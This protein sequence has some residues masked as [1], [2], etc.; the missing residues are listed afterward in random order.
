MTAV[1]DKC[2]DSFLEHSLFVSDDDVGSFQLQHLFKA[3]VTVD[4]TSVKVVQVGG[5][6]SAA[7]QHYHRTKIGRDYGNNVQYHPLGL[8]LGETE[9]LDDVQSLEELYSL[10]TCG[11]ILQLVFQLVG[12]PFK[13]VD[14]LGL[15]SDL[16]IL[17]VLVSLSDLFIKQL[18]DV[19]G[20]VD[21]L[22]A[23][24]ASLFLFHPVVSG[25]G[26]VI[27]ISGNELTNF[28]FLIVDVVSDNEKSLCKSVSDLLL[29]KTCY[30]S[31]LVNVLD[32]VLIVSLR[33]IVLKEILNSLCT[34]CSIEIVLVLLAHIGI[35]LF[36]EKL[37][38]DKLGV[39]SVN[40]DI[41]CKVKDL[42]KTL[43]GNL[44]HLTDPGRCT[45][46][47]PD[48]GAGSS[49]SNVTHTLTSYL[50]TGNFNAA[51]LADLALKADLLILT[52]VTLPVL[53]RTKDPFAVKAVSF[54]LLC[55]VVDGFRL[56]NSAV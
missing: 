14:P 5:S 41:F 21:Y 34:H 48:V 32:D 2:I 4:N 37:L 15:V 39:T 35:F 19:L 11:Q 28:I 16:I 7:V 52:A 45:L 12:Y 44:K 1:V 3:V 56:F 53:G 51:A 8:V 36:R 13:A 30:S 20:A 24:V 55:S 29:G 40:N 47:V 9:G 17:A 49:K 33:V 10:L 18:L 23:V 43:L 27:L 31:E 6:I 46:E 50:C 42:F 38:L 54:G 26:V 25:D 22:D